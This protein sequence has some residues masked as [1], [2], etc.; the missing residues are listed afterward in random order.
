MSNTVDTVQVFPPALVPI[1]RER[2]V[3]SGRVVAEASDTVLEHLLT[4]VFFAGLETH[5]GE[6]APVRV[7]F[8]GRSQVD[9]ILPTGQEAGAI[10]I[11]AWK[12]LRFLSMRPFAVPELVKLA[13]ATTDERVYIAVRLLDDGSL[14]V[15]GLAREGIG[16]DDD[17]FLKLVA[18]H[19]GGLSVR[20]GRDRL[21]E[22]ERGTI[23]TGGKNDVVEPK[24]VRT[25]LEE[26]ARS[27]GLDDE[28]IPEYLKAVRALVSEM[29]AHGRGGILVIHSS[30]LPELGESAPYRMVA[31]S[32]LASLLRLSKIISHSADHTE[33]RTAEHLTFGQVLRSA[34]I[35]ESERMIEEV[36]AL[37]A[38]DGATLL[39]RELALVAF[40]A[41][42][43]V[44]EQSEVRDAKTGLP[45]DLGSRGTRHRASAVCASRNP[46]SVVF[47]ASADGGVTCLLRSPNDDH[48]TMWLM[49][50]HT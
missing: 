26:A 3:S 2:C 16:L 27:A 19:P 42:L 13:V 48:V 5:E 12:T 38:I 24:P 39:N 43:P 25:S 49:G 7:V 21:S 37:T 14:G 23:L 9:L 10:P 15:A 6:R 41:I 11:Y 46:G 22:Y 29:V 4:T 33:S 31:G 30:E 18:V 47:V 20:S 44:A 8:V 35:S 45:A 34:F 1:I 28:T 32:S 17:P 50:V 40:G 36:G